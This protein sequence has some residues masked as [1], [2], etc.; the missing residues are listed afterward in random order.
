MGFYR[1]VFERT[2]MTVSAR[3]EVATVLISACWPI[4]QFVQ[5]RAEAR[6]STAFSVC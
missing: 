1:V 6:H 3:R 5:R 2:V 4:D